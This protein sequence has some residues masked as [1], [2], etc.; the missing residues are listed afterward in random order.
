M[1]IAFLLS[2][3]WAS[4]L[5]VATPAKV[6]LY[7]DLGSRGDNLVRWGLILRESP[8]VDLTLLD[9][10]DLRRGALTGLDLLVMPGGSGFDQYASMGEAGAQA[11]RDY[12]RGGGR[13]FGTC[14]GLALALNEPHRVAL[15]PFKR[16]PGQWPR[17]GGDLAVEFNDRGAELLNLGTNR[18]WTIRYHNG[19]ILQKA[20]AIPD[21]RAEVIA[22]CKGSV[23]ERGPGKTGM[24][25]SPAF[26]HAVVGRGEVLACNCHP[27]AHCATRALIG[28][29]FRRL[30]G[31]AVSLP[32]LGDEPYRGQGKAA[33]EKRL[34][35]QR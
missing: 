2:V 20:E 25:D 29:A 33:L 8:D 7:C 3:V 17:G 5:G 18:C 26:V 27:E 19:P 14:A 11:I 31:R 10:D 1:R 32:D 15:L 22:L 12:V 21:V 6:G 13:Y 30:L 35:L 16:V 28:A 4:L 34:R 9:G 23:C 24:Y